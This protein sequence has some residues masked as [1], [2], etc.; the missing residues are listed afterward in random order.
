[1]DD[2]LKTVIDSLAAHLAET[3]GEIGYWGDPIAEIGPP[4]SASKNSRVPP[5]PS[6]ADK[7]RRLAYLKDEV[8]GDCHLCPL[9]DTRIKLVF[10]VG[11]PD[12]EVLFVGEGP[13]FEEDRKGE[14]FVG[15]AGQLLDRILRAIDLDR[16]NVYIANVVKCHPMINPGRPELR[17]NDRPPGA[18]EMETCFPF[19]KEQISIINPKIIVTLGATAARAMLQTGSG[20]SRIRGT[21]QSV[22]FFDNRP[23][24]PVLP[25]YH[26]AAL[27]RD[28]SLKR[29]VWEDMKLLKRFLAGH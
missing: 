23:P 20:I 28:E 19:L 17:G 7:G 29:P 27:L 12:A 3:D 6:V 24:I 2:N 16:S 8:I 11:N 9:G 5:T 18:K 4:R 14:P 15:K 1:M 10:G 21:L 13:G 25:T 26:P 22:S